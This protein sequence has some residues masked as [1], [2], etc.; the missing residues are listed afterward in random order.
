M[1]RREIPLFVFAIPRQHNIGAFDYLVCTDK[2]NGF[3]ARVDYVT[4]MPEMASD[5]V[6]VGLARG[7]IAMRMEIKRFTGAN[8]K[9]SEVRTLMK[10]GMDYCSKIMTVKVDND[11][12]SVDDCSAFLERLIQGNRANWGKLSPIERA[13]TQKS[14]EMLTATL[15]HLKTK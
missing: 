7:G 14:L 10:M 5:S 9:P 3:V 12:P 15:E 8:V 6:R 11:A 13:T 4:D 2:D 1:A